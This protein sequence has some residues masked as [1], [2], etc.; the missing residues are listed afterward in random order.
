MNLTIHIHTP[1]VIELVVKVKLY[2]KTTI[3]ALHSCDCVEFKSV[4]ICLSLSLK[5]QNVM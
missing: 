3:K 5:T 1:P 4:L 2:S